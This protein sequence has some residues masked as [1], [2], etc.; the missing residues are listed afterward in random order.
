[1]H[2]WG[3]PGNAKFSYRAIEEFTKIW[4]SGTLRS[5]KGGRMEKHQRES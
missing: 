3:P 4:G 2:Q 1:M 5:A